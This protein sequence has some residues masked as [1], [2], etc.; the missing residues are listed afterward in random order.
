M[1]E[2]PGWG[3]PAFPVKSFPVMEGI[4]DQAQVKRF[5]VWIYS[6]AWNGR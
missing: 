1:P 3:A 5:T 4:A 6:R 2:P